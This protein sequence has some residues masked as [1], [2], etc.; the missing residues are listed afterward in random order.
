MT[1]FRYFLSLWPDVMGVHTNHNNADRTGG[2]LTIIHVLVHPQTKPS[3]SSSSFSFWHLAEF[4][5]SV[6]FSCWRKIWTSFPLLIARSSMVSGA[7][8]LMIWETKVHFCHYHECIMIIITIHIKGG[9]HRPSSSSSSSS[10]PYIPCKEGSRRPSSRT[11]RNRPS[12]AAACGSHPFQV[13]FN[14]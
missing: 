2:K 13:I 12:S 3:S 6:R 8:R 4:L 9:S 14:H 1:M 11:C 7:A 10:S 5:A